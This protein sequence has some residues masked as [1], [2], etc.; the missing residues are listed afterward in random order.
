MSVVLFFGIG[1]SISILSCLVV[2]QYLRS[3]GFLDMPGARS[4][5]V[6]PTPKGGGVGM[7]LALAGM[8]L[9]SGLSAWLWLPLACLSVLSFANDVRSIAPG[10]RLLIQG[11]AALASLGWAWWTGV[12]SWPLILLVPAIFFVMATANCYNFMD[13]ING[14]AG[15]TG[16]VALFGLTL[17]LALTHGMPAL[18]GPLVAVLGA[19][20]AFLPFNVPRAR[21]FMG[22]VGSI[23]LGFF[24]AVSMCLLSRS[25]NEFLPFTALLFPFYADEAVSV[26]VRVQRRESLLRPH[27]LHLYQILANEAGFAHWKISL[28]YCCIQACVALLA[29]FVA[30]HGP[31]AVLAMLSAAFAFWGGTQYTIM[32]H[33]GLVPK[34]I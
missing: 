33:Y 34:D 13:G 11:V 6:V 1:L 31:W 30:S 2:P 10:L 25:W 27:R 21:L 26:I 19:V 3:R 17:Y 29:V 20:C 23:F 15:L 28:S 4:S 32:R 14:M 5:H 24:I 22:D 9:F 7:V 12:V 8:A 18:F 16:V